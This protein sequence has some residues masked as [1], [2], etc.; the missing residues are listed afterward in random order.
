MDSLKLKTKRPLLCTGERITRTVVVG[1]LVAVDL[2]VQAVSWRGPRQSWGAGFEEEE[3]EKYKDQKAVTSHRGG[4]GSCCFPS[5][6]REIWEW[7]AGR[8][9]KPDYRQGK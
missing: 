3:E 4:V 7:E 9:I 5:R 6:F 8:E 1:G 2:V